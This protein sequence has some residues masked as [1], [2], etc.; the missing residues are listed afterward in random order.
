[1][2][3][4]NRNAGKKYV[5]STV[6]VKKTTAEAQVRMHANPPLNAASHMGAT[7]LDV[8]RVAGGLA[9]AGTAASQQR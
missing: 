1:M 5:W 9:A 4:R 3:M 7:W 6:L 2:S 8:L